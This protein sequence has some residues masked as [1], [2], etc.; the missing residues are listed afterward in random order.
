M[1]RIMTAYGLPV[2]LEKKRCRHY[3]IL[4]VTILNNH[5]A[6]VST[7]ETNTTCYFNLLSHF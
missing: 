7:S 5:V 4:E 1:V 2:Y 3:F 6:A